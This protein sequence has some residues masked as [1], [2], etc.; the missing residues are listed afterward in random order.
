MRTTTTHLQVWK[1]RQAALVALAVMVG[2]RADAEDPI[3]AGYRVRQED[4]V[5]RSNVLLAEADKAGR[6]LTTQERETIRENSAEVERLEGEITLRAQ[7]AAQDQRLRQPQARVTPPDAGEPAAEAAAAAQPA[8]TQ[9]RAETHVQ[10]THISTAATRA[11]QRGNGGFNNLGNFAQAVRMATRNPAAMDNRL[12]AALTTYGN[13]ST[14]ADGGFAVPPDFRTTIMEQ[15]FDE[16]QLFSMCDATPT[17]SNRVTLL[18]DETTPWGTSGV[19]VYTRA[20]AAAMT[21]SKLSLKEFTTPLHEI[22]ALCPVTDEQLEDAP[23]LTSHMSKKVGEALQFKLTDWIVNG[24]GAG[25]MLGILKSPALVTVSA[26]GSQTADTIHAENIISMWSRMPGSVRGRAVWLANQDSEPQ[27]MKLGSVV[28]TAT[29]TAVGGTPAYL[30][31]GGL[32]ASPYGTLLGRP[33]ITTE[34][35]SALGDVGDIILA[36]MPGFFAPYKAGGV[37]SDVSMHLFFDQGVTAFRWVMRAGGQPW[38][39]APIARK[40]GSNTLSHFVT[41]AAR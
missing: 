36:Y 23:M 18:A 14:G 30:P 33:V 19:R 3:V 10:T 41:L 7:V 20:E 12:V 32:S 15:M 38:L 21:Q 24:T 35:C 16:Q 37:K 1:S 25:Q 9:A 11:A 4:L 2:M 8:R 29:G 5:Q 17:A 26:V 6:E 39:S 40:N 22:Y 13:E 28:T 27:L 34:A 31:P